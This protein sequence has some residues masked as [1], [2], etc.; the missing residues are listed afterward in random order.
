VP[1][2]LRPSLRLLSGQLEVK[3]AGATG[4]P[5]RVLPSVP[6]ATTFTCPGELPR[7][8]VEAT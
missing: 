5:A 8:F 4:Q 6:M 1:A 3:P 2:G 7:T